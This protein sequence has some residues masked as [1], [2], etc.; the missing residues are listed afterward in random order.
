MA[1]MGTDKHQYRL[2][3]R[4]R[5]DNLGSPA[6][7]TVKML[8]CIVGVDPVPMFIRKCHIGDDFFY[9]ILKLLGCLLKLRNS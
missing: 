7:F 2:A 4:E 3:T 9:A 6:D 1:Q 8:N 5:T